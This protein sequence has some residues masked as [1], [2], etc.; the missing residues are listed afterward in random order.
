[1]GTVVSPR[2]S[3]MLRKG[4]H[5]FR[6]SFN[7]AFRVPSIVQNYLDLTIFNPVAV[8][9]AFET[10]ASGKRDLS[11]ERLDAVEVGWVGDFGRTLTAAFSIYRNETSDLIDL[12]PATH[13]LDGPFAGLPRTIT[14]RNVGKLIDKGI[15]VS[16]RSRRGPGFSWFLNYSFQDRPEVEGIPLS[17]VN[18]PPR[19]RANVGFS[20]D[21][22]RL[23]LSGNA[24]YQDD[25]VWTD[26]L[27]SRFHGP[28]NSFVQVNASVG[29]RFRNERTTLTLTGN[30][31]F[32][33]D[34]QQ[35]VFGD[36]ISRKIAANVR[37]AF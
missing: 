6:I 3:L 11:E 35:H 13:Y 24:N 23:F 37:F 21:K 28:T 27:D 22:G 32:D 8:G 15:E 25:A 19:H 17:E 18:L 16:A 36:I 29:L 30:N 2:T 7:R 12:F 9:V 20:Y 5:N 34:I 31:V 1:I 10:E 14:Y 33:D 26:V 4:K